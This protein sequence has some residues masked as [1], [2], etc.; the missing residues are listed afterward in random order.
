MVFDQPVHLIK[1]NRQELDLVDDDRTFTVGRDAVGETL[2]VCQKLAARPG[3]K[4][5]DVDA[6]WKTMPKPERLPRPPGP[7]K[8]IVGARISEESSQIRHLCIQYGD[9]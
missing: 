1:K 3:F 6:F 8:E 5:I 2:R 4:E 9:V 7:E